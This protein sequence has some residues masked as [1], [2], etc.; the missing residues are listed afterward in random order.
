M[1][2]EMQFSCR[3]ISFCGH[4]LTILDSSANNFNWEFSP[5]TVSESSSYNFYI[6][7]K[8]AYEPSSL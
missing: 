5:K 1:N 3:K 7:Q 8:Q 2:Y 6:T 4:N